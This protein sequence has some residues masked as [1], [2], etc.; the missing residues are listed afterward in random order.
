MFTDEQKLSCAVGELVH[1]LGNLIVDKDLLFGG[2]TWQMGR[3]CK[4]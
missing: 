3:Y 2:L 1:N 4:H